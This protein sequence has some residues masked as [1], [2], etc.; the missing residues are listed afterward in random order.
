LNKAFN[1]Q[2]AVLPPEHPDLLATYNRFALTYAGINEIDMALEYYNKCLNIRL[3]TLPHD[4]PDIATSYNNLGWL[5]NERIGDYVK[6]L[7]FFQK[8]LAI[9]RKTLPPTHRD[10]IRTEQ[11]IR[12]VNEKLKEKS[13]T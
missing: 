1:I 8:S 11:N 5:Y 3:A 2:Q 7:D 10:I 4:H 13:K 9:C 12:K 6:A